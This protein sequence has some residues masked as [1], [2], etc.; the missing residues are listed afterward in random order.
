MNL[1]CTFLKNLIKALLG[2]EAIDE[3][4]KEEVLYKTGYSKEAELMIQIGSR[5]KITIFEKRLFQITTWLFVLG[6]F[7]FLTRNFIVVMF[8]FALFL[9][10]WYPLYVFPFTLRVQRIFFIFTVWLC[11][12]WFGVFSFYLSIISSIFG[13]NEIIF[14]RRTLMGSELFYRFFDLPLDALWVVFIVLMIPLTILTLVTYRRISFALV[15]ILITTAVFWY[16]Y[17]TIDGLPDQSELSN[18]SYD[19]LGNKV[20]LGD[21]KGYQRKL[22][23]ISDHLTYKE[24]FISSVI[25]PTEIYYYNKLYNKESK[26]VRDFF[27]NETKS[28]YKNSFINEIIG[29]DD[30]EFIRSIGMEYCS[31]VSKYVW[32]NADKIDV[33][34][35]KTISKIVANTKMADYKKLRVEEIVQRR[36]AGKLCISYYDYIIKKARQE[37]GKK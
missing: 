10:L 4:D 19:R 30:K 12:F 16:S 1:V 20:K 9:G 36:S 31:F 14:D 26:C 35:S 21:I 8:Y 15:F 28:K 37:C 3:R 32:R 5:N 22:K 6:F 17:E 34:N 2:K 24:D 25:K 13:F 33:P 11:A 29:R 23:Y 27:V 7:F 18:Y